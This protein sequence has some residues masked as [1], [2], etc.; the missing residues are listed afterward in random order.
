LAENE[1][2]T[3]LEKSRVED[4]YKKTVWKEFDKRMFQVFEKSIHCVD[5]LYFNV[6]KENRIGERISFKDNEVLNYLQDLHSMTGELYIITDYCYEHD[7]GPFMVGSNEL[8]RFVNT[9]P[10]YNF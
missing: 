5:G 4:M 7:Y 2:V 8:E 10:V 1:C 9:S 3:E 6:I